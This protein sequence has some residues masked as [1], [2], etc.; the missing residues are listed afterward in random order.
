MAQDFGLELRDSDDPL[1]LKT[2]NQRV[3]KIPS[4]KRGYIDVDNFPE[5]NIKDN[6][7]NFLK[8]E[9]SFER[10]KTREY[11]LGPGKG[12]LDRLYACLVDQMVIACESGFRSADIKRTAQ[13]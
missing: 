13:D 8:S 9:I 6:F 2:I 11:C 10:F 4:F 3:E 7:T 1:M 12:Y 5:K